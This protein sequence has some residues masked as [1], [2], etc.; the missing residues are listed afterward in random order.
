[1]AEIESALV[2]RLK[3]R[4]SL[5]SLV[6]AR[7]YPL[8]LPQSPMLPAVTYQRIGG[9][10]EEGLTADPGFARQRIQVDTWALTYASAKAVAHQ[11]RLAL[12]R[13]SDDSA[14]PRVIDSFIERDTDLDE[15]GVE[16]YRVS[17]DYLVIHAEEVA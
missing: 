9:P 3:A 2:T 11:V 1:M 4:P 15:P 6:G 13:W 7:I 10:R 14:S 8:R 5:V 17:Q 16:N 12:E